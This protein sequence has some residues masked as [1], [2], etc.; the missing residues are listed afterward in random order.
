MRVFSA[1][2]PPRG[3][4]NGGGGGPSGPR[5]CAQTGDLENYPG[6]TLWWSPR[7]PAGFTWQPSASLNQSL[8]G[9]SELAKVHQELSGG[10]M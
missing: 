4:L 9:L 7:R 2:P 5:G 10:E 3:A 6:S 1:P 8:A